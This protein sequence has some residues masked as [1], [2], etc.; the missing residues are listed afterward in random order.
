MQTLHGFA[1][2]VHAGHGSEKKFK[3]PKT[4]QDARDPVKKR[5]ILRGNTGTNLIRE[6]GF[7]QFY[8]AECNMAT[9][10]KGILSLKPNMDAG[11]DWAKGYGVKKDTEPEF[12]VGPCTNVR[13]MLASCGTLVREE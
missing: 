1:T 4:E 13:R 12:L 2:P 6:L 11:I 10:V 5:D 7:T 9:R 3:K 8:T